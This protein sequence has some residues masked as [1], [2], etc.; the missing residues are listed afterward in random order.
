VGIGVVDI[1][2]FYVESAEDIAARIREALQYIDPQ[3]AFINP[4]CGFFQLPR[5]LTVLKL[6]RMVEATRLVRHELTG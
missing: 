5:W 1:K 6:R 3:Q 4:D 2:S